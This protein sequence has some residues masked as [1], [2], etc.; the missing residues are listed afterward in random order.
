[1]GKTP[2][3]E[4]IAE[5]L[6]WELVCLDVE[7]EQIRMELGVAGRPFLDDLNFLDDQSARLAVVK[8]VM[9]RCEHAVIDCPGD[10]LVSN[11][12][13]QIQE[14]KSALSRAYVIAMTPSD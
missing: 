13:V 8:A 7:G 2:M 4:L 1:M 9:D 11:D 10:Y 3:S 6:G 5:R 12:A 14:F